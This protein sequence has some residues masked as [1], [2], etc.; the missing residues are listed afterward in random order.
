MLHKEFWGLLFLAFV[1]WIFVSSSP[2]QR[3]EHFC[4]PVGWA[5]NVSTSVTALLVPTQQVSVQRWFDKFE[6]GCQY[7]TWRLLYQAEYNKALGL[8]K[9]GAPLTQTGAQAPVKAAEGTTAAPN[10]AP[11]QS[12]TAPAAEKVAK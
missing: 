12:A 4:Q 6:Y 11:A 10:T 5:G 7:M 3:I 2:T 1:G 8:D 9:N